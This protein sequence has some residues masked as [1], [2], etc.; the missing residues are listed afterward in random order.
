MADFIYCLNSSTI[1]PTPI[2][3]KI[4]IAGETG[5]K[6][7]ELWHDDIDDHLQKGGT[8]GEIRWALADSDLTVPTT[9]YLKGWFETTGTEHVHGLEECKRRMHQAA[10]LGA[11]H[12]IA[13]PPAGKA[14]HNQGARNYRELLEIGRKIGVKPAMEYLGFVEDINTIEAAAE[15][16]HKADH[17]DATIVHDPFHIFRGGGSLD[18]LTRLPAERIAV[19]HFNDT[20]TDPPRVQQHDKDR[21]MPGRGHLDLRRMLSLLKQI[22]YNRWLSLELFREDLWAQDPRKVAKEGLEAMRAVAETA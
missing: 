7:I 3:D 1:R 9:I 12:V 2:L 5:Y 14:D 10:E 21:V 20:P 16:I 13:G 18:S 17:P 19:C 22:G 4:R 6:A 15:I 8:L 11:I